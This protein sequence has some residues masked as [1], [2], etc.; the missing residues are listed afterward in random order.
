LQQTI[1]PSVESAF[2]EHFV[3]ADGFHIRYFEAGS[4]AP[5]ICL[6]G[7]SGLLLTEGHV[8]LSQAFRVIAF[9]MPGFGRSPENARTNSVPELASTLSSAISG[10]GIE[11]F[12]LLGWSFGSRVALWL[13]LQQPEHVSAL[14]LEAPGAIRVGPRVIPRSHEEMAALLFKNPQRWETVA[15][16]DPA[17]S[18]K[19][20]TLVNRIR[21]P[22]HD[23]AFQERLREIKAPTLVL[24]GTEDRLCSPDAGR[25]YEELL[26]NCSLVFVYDAAHAISGDRPEAF[27]EVVSDFLQRHEA[28]VISRRDTKI[29]P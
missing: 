16:S 22:E 4:G 10:I 5:L 13:T 15:R 29:F 9:E 27:V 26:P 19:E 11:T 24:F 6:H 21:G 12:S 3:D 8:L 17:V 1:T 14:V 7:A 28:F 25:I 2:S 18:A 20:R 23:P